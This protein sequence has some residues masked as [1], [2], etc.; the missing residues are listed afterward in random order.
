MSYGHGCV[1]VAVLCAFTGTA[2]GAPLFEDDFSDGNADGWSELRGNWSVGVDGW[3]Y[4]EDG[5]DAYSFAGDESWTDY[6][7]TL[8]ADGVPG[9][10]GRTPGMFIVYFRVTGAFNQG[11]SSSI[12]GGTWYRLDVWQAD[13]DFSPRLVNVWRQ[14]DTRS[15]HKIFEEVFPWIGTDPMD[16]T[17]TAVGD[18]IDVW[19][20][21][22][23]VV[24]LTN[25]A[26]PSGRIGVSSI[27]EGTARFDDIVVTP[28]PATLSLMV[29]GALA[30]RRRRRAR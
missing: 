18:Q 23:Q 17:I 3:Y 2:V 20:D 16:V 14:T 28:E 19:L 29:V 26:N 1:V 27:W 21:G 13:G 15:Q 11:G 9:G 12:P 22:N 4:G 24:D 30:L 6:T 7:M 5:T 25:N 8:Q 10:T